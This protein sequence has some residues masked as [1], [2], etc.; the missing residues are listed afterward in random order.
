[1]S[2][3]EGSVT[4]LVLVNGNFRD[5]VGTVRYGDVVSFHVVG[6]SSTSV[7]AASA[8]DGAV[9]VAT[10]LGGTEK[11]VLVANTLDI[12]VTNTFITINPV[13]ILTLI[14]RTQSQDKLD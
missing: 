1:M 9:T 2:L 11:W 14:A 4:E 6:G 7:V 10:A 3:S 5:D 8:T 12:V 13:P